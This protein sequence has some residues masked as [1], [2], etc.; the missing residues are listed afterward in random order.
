MATLTLTHQQDLELRFKAASTRDLL[1]NGL[2]LV[3]DRRLSEANKDSVMM[4]LSAGVS[5]LYDLALGLRDLDRH[6]HW[7]APQ[8]PG[9]Q[10]RDLAT[11][12]NRVFGFLAEQPGADLT[13]DR[14]LNRVAAD[15]VLPP[16]LAALSVYSGSTVP[17][18]L[19]PVAWDAVMDAV[20]RDP[21]VSSRLERAMELDTDDLWAAYRKAWDERLAQAVE[22]I[23]FALA[24]C[25]RRGLLGE[26]GTS[27]GREIVTR[28]PVLRVAA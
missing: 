21:G 24:V 22:T 1:S 27:F 14:W 10:M 11:T 28:E 13:V 6:G 18:S 17:A 25:G 19:G 8:P 3:R 5:R 20:H 2:R 26:A 9:P 23:W 12:H 15:P 7:T 16:L 4:T